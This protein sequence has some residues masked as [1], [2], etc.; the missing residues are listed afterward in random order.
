[1]GLI[2]RCRMAEVKPRSREAGRRRCA[3]HGHW[4]GGE[5]PLRGELVATASRRQLH[6]VTAVVR[7]QSWR[8]EAVWRRSPR[9][10]AAPNASEPLSKPDR[11]GERV[12]KRD[13]SADHSSQLALA[14]TFGQLRP[15]SNRCRGGNGGGSGGTSSVLTQGDLRGSAR[16][17]DPEEATTT[18]RCLRRSRISS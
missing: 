10:T 11:P 8:R 17:V 6:A 5:S 1:L 3:W 7:R 2:S 18:G 14:G 12:S 15:K 13:P 9:R 4:I 16:A